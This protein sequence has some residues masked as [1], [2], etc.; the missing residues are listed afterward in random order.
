M[1]QAATFKIQINGAAAVSCESLRLAPTSIRFESFQADVLSLVQLLRGGDSPA[2]VHDDRVRL[3][4]VDESGTEAQVFCGLV[5]APRDDGGAGVRLVRYTV[6]G[7]LGAFA[8]WTFVRGYYNGTHIHDGVVYE[9]HTDNFRNSPSLSMYWGDVWQ[10]SALFGW[11]YKRTRPQNIPKAAREVVEYVAGRVQAEGL[12]DEWRPELLSNYFGDAPLEPQWSMVVSKNCLDW[13]VM[14]CRPQVDAFSS[15]DYSGNRPGLRLGRFRDV[16]PVDL[17]GAGWPMVSVSHSR[18]LDKEPSGLVVGHGVGANGFPMEWLT[19]I[20]EQPSGQSWLDRNNLAMVV[21]QMPTAP[22]SVFGPLMY[23]S[24]TRPIVEA[25]V[26]LAG[27]AWQWARPG[28]TLSVV[29]GG[30][31]LNIQT[32]TWDLGTDVVSVTVGLPRQLGVKDLD[33][34]KL[35]LWRHVRDGNDLSTTI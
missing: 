20:A 26:K 33:D 11:Y 7:G 15:V 27:D 1:A 18:R 14:V 12:G 3:I 24:A 22:P 5:Q 6:I 28:R 21:A 17:T 25:Q 19:P 29:T 34:I 30:G 16:E 10:Y 13:L 35:W 4:R 32:A 9:V 2:L 31:D 8:Q 23:A